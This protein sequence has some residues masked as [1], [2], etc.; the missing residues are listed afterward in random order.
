MY[1][2]MNKLNDKKGP[3]LNGFKWVCKLD[4]RSL[5]TLKD[6]SSTLSEIKQGNNER[7]DSIDRRINEVESSI[8]VKVQ[9]EVAELK[10]KL[11]FELSDEIDKKLELRLKEEN[12]RRFR[13]MNLVLFNVPT[14][15]DK[16]T[17]I[18]KQYDLDIV[19]SLFQAVVKDEAMKEP[20]I[21]NCFRL[22]MRKDEGSKPLEGSDSDG[23][24]PVTKYP[25]LKV[26]FVRK[27]DIAC[28]YS[29]F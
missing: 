3:G 15:T 29:E 4:E 8:G 19:V 25:V 7:F 27:Q 18:R 12:E 16:N 10:E 11:K 20:M 22:A 26:T 24:Q 5:P 9:D 21:K 23:D 17:E 1:D 6:M 28:I 13:E 14:S 2:L